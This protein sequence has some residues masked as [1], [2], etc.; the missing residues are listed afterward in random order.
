MEPRK[1]HSGNLLEK[2]QPQV[3]VKVILSIIPFGHLKTKESYNLQP[4]P[5]PADMSP[6]L[7]SEFIFPAETPVSRIVAASQPLVVGTH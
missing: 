2:E 1:S 4:P 7:P 6:S 3:N 5:E